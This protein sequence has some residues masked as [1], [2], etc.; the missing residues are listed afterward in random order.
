MKIDVILFRAIKGEPHHPTAYDLAVD[1]TIVQVAYASA[2]EGRT[3]VLV[4]QT[5]RLG[6]TWPPARS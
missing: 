4:E 1:A 3:I 5:W 6:S 2:I